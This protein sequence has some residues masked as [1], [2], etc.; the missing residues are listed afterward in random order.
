MIAWHVNVSVLGGD[1]D[2]FFLTEMDMRHGHC[3]CN[4]RLN[5]NKSA[6]S[7]HTHTHTRAVL[8]F[9]LITIVTNCIYIKTGGAT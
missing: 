5:K 3:N 1:L 9:A 8:S 2:L 7:K 4:C 6:S